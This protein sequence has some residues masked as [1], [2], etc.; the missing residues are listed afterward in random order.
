MAL[1]F[2]DL[3]TCCFRF[4]KGRPHTLQCSVT[5]DAMVEQF[6]ARRGWHRENSRSCTH[7][8]GNSTCICRSVQCG[9][10]EYFI[11]H[12]IGVTIGGIWICNRILWTLTAVIRRNKNSWRIYTVLQFIIAFTYSS[13]YAF[14]SSV[15][16]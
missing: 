12:V 11:F 10:W 2:T 1:R 15:L 6:A 9:T 16:W 4:S 7:S 3:T 13:Q 14:F 8:R 5:D